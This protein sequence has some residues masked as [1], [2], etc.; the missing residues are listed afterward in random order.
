MRAI[1]K[2]QFELGEVAIADIKIDARSRDDIPAILRGLQEM[3]RH[4]ETR[5]KL[6]EK[7]EQ[8]LETKASRTTGRPGMELWRI[9][10]LA[11]LKQGLDCD[12]DRLQEL[13]NHHR[14]L[15]QMLGHSD[16]FDQSEYKMQTLVDNVSLLSPK[17]LAEIS[18]LIVETGHEVVK[19]KPGD[20]LRGRCDSVVIETDVHYPTDTNLLWDAMRTVIRQTGQACESY[21]VSGWRQYHYHSR[22]LKQRFRLTQKLR[23]SN[24]KD[25][26]KQEQKR[27]QV[28]QA[29][30]DY[31]SHAQSLCE[32]VE[33][34]LP[35]LAES[36]A[37]L[38]IETLKCYLAHAQ[39]QID[40]ITRRVLLGETIPHEEKVFSLFEPH[41]RWLCKGKAGKPVELGV[42][43][44][45]LE[46]QHQFIL[47]HRI[48]WDETDDQVAVAMVKDT[49]AR[50]GDLNQ[51]SFDRGFHSPANRQA[52]DELL[53]HNILPKKGRLSEA[54]QAREYSEA[55]VKARRQHSAVESCIN[56]LEHH[57]LE[58][59]RAYG[60][61]GFERTV[62]LSV[63][64]YNLHRLGKL[65]QKRERA[66]LAK[67]ARR[68]A[69]LRL[70]A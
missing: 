66:R 43:V 17:V 24:S 39:R 5:E 9:F 67:Q 55:F 18:Q 34:T 49:Q 56:S 61:K 6:F 38:E 62:A 14:T 57:G 32:K 1:Q 41:T 48:M 70:A 35:M 25:P 15:R 37:V 60:K 65:L 64:A 10:V 53:E 44:C 59:C 20:A 22:Q 47:H 46:D 16:W 23:Y 45:V 58:R 4:K 12:F 33:A 52:L 3:Y 42:A 28:H 19:K 27:Q 11:T 29:Y 68:E 40:Q 50:F 69:R 8:S 2:S 31:L 51:C 30:C 36:G 63:V 26:D 21:G 54:D 13:A 7:L